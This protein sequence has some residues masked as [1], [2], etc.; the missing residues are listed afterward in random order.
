M[1]PSS[2]SAASWTRA[3]SIKGT[4][5]WACQEGQPHVREGGLPLPTSQ[6]STDLVGSMPDSS[7][8]LSQSWLRL[9][10]LGHQQMAGCGDGCEQERLYRNPLHR[11]KGGG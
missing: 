3:E 1:V 9:C 7:W 8:V 11:G 5:N 10:E 4:E 6:L 2:H